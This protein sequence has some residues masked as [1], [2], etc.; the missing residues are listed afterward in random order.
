MWCFQRAAVGTKM[1]R[2]V[3]EGLVLKLATRELRLLTMSATE[4]YAAF[5]KERAALLSRLSR[6]EL[7]NTSGSRR[8]P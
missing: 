6:S 8:S 5:A 7:S 2:G 1:E 4:R 3:L